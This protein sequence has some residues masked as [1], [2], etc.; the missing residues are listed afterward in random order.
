MRVGFFATSVLLLGAVPALAN[1]AA[2]VSWVGSWAAAPM[3]CPV[4]SGGPSAGDSTYRNAMRL[5]AGGKSVRVVLTNEF[6]ATQLMVGSARIGLDAGNGAVKPGSDHAL[7]FGGRPS[8]AIPTGGLMLS[9]AVPMDVAA[10]SSLSVSVY[11][12]DQVIATRTC[13]ALA[14]ATNYVVKGDAVAS[15]KMAGA[16]KLESWNFVKGIDVAAEPNAAA[17]VALGDSITDGA[18]STKDANRRWTDDLAERLQKSPAGMRVG[19]LNEGMIGN[20]VLRMELG[21]NAIA[22]FDRDVLAQ[23]G[24]RYLILLEGINDFKWDDPSELASAE[25]LKVGLSQLIE[26]AHAHGMVVLLGTLLPYAGADGFTDDGEQVR[27][28]VNQWIRSGGVA[29]GVID[30]DKVMR[31]PSKPTVLL[32]AYD[33]GDHLHPNDAGYKAMADSIDLNLLS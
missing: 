17:I 31:D 4:R 24:A 16:R 23:S 10:L 15:A 5:S 20:R 12:P 28:A 21:P 32:P 30:F 26:R 19:V 3:A 33:S 2:R 25:E 13:H 6:G 8:V 18:A 29:D 14:S 27:S 7:T 1:K 9:D 11:V 22:R